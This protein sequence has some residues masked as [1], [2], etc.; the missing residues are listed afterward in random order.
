MKHNRL[1][2]YLV[3]VSLGL[4]KTEAVVTSFDTPE[5]ITISSSSPNSTQSGLHSTGTTRS[6]LFRFNNLIGFGNDQVTPGSTIHSA[7]LRFSGYGNS[8]N[9]HRMIANW[10]SSL[11]WN[12]ATLGGNTTTGIQADGTEAATSSVAIN[13]AITSDVSLSILNSPTSSGYVADAELW[14]D[15]DGGNH[16]FGFSQFAAGETVMTNIPGR[17]TNVRLRAWAVG[18][19]DIFDLTFAEAEFLSTEVWGVAWSPSW[20]HLNITPAPFFD[21]ELDVTSD[22]SAWAN[23]TTNQGWAFLGGDWAEDGFGMPVLEVN[24][25][26][27]PI[28]EPSTLCL[29]FLGIGAIYRRRR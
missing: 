14:Y 20:Q 12:T 6:S 15:L 10:S 25:D 23:G 16:N 2:F 3:V 1:P 5:A 21:Y 8:P 22:V 9:L 24:Y 13:T 18:G 26:R 29:A 17:A 11:T 28:P 7:T 27:A 4:E 19:F